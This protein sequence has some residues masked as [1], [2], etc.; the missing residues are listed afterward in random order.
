MVELFIYLTKSSS[1]A[2]NCNGKSCFTNKY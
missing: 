1:H 2:P